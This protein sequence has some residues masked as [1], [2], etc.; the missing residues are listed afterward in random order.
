M[1]A[2]AEASCLLFDPRGL[3]TRCVR[4]P[5]QGN[6]AEGG[7]GGSQL[8]AAQSKAAQ[9]A[10]AKAEA[11]AAA[12]AAAKAAAAAAAAAEPP[13]LAPTADGPRGAWSVAWVQLCLVVF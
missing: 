11:V 1:G 2:G 12:A 3:L 9:K 4:I 13:A 6:A 8:V 10:A 7:P 5:L